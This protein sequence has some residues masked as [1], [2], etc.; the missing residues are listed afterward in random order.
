MESH[1][2]DAVR[3]HAEVSELMA[4]AKSK[5][6]TTRQK[7]TRAENKA[8]AVEAAKHL[9]Q[10][11]KGKP[12]AVRET[13]SAILDKEDDVIFSPAEDSLDNLTFDPAKPL[14]DQELNDLG[15][16][17]FKAT[18]G[19]ENRRPMATTETLERNKKWLEGFNEHQK[20]A[21]SSFL[22]RSPARQAVGPGKT[23]SQHESDKQQGKESL[24]SLNAAKA[25]E[26]ITKD[27][28]PKVPMK[29]K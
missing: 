14:G 13:K 2:K 7:A 27:T 19:Q 3:S 6:K 15:A 5:L 16:K 9:V 26:K 4:N 28:R 21:D 12:R 17:R 24:K 22:V 23:D 20:T 1:D 25:C 11:A 10:G 29:K 8:R 18:F